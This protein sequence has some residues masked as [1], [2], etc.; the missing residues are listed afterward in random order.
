MKYELYVWCRRNGVS[1]DGGLHSRLEADSDCDAIQ[2]LMRQA[3]RDLL[4][5][6]DEVR[7]VIKLN[8]TVVHRETI[9]PRSSCIG[10]R[11]ILAA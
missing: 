2:E 11:S 10:R 4:I 3:E 1:S 6:F 5:C 8:G 9:Y 7:C